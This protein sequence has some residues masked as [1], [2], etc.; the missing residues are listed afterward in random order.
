MH[1]IS[2]FRR[3]LRKVLE[4][5]KYRC[6]VKKYGLLTEA[7]RTLVQKKIDTLDLFS[8]PKISVVM[9]VCNPPLRFLEEAV[10][11]VT[12]QIYPH[13]ELCIVD[14][15]S[16]DEAI[17]MWLRALEQKGLRIKINFLKKR[18][19]IAA[20]TNAALRMASGEF[21][22][23][24]DHDDCFSL[25]AL[26][27][28]ALAIAAIPNVAYLYSDEDKIDA[29]GERCDPFFKP[30]WNPDLLTSL[31]YCS[32][33]SIIRKVIIDEVGGLNSDL[34]GAQDWDLI[35]RVTE[36]VESN[37][38]I[39]LPKVLYHW[40][41]SQNSTARSIRAKP[42][43][44]IASKKVL[45]QALERRG[46]AAI[47]IDLVMAGGHWKVCH[48][49][50]D[51]L[52]FVS[53]IILTHSSIDL[54]K[55]CIESLCSQT[56]YKHY[57]ILI[58]DSNSHD[59]KTLRYYSQIKKEKNIRIIPSPDASNYS[60]MN[61]HAVAHARGEILLLLNNTMEV[62]QPGW[63]AE[64]VAQAV[65]PEVGA[66]GALLYS[67]NGRVQYAGTIL[68]M[69]DLAGDVGK[70]FR[71]QHYVGGN[72]M[73][74]VQNFSALTGACL[75]VRKK[76]YEEVG[77]FDQID[78]P[79]AFSDIDFCLKLQQAGYR[80]VWTPFAELIHHSLAS[81]APE[82]KKRFKK[83]AALLRLRWGE[84]IKDDPAYNPNLTLER[85]DWS[86]AWPP[87]K[88]EN[89]GQRNTCF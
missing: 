20:A 43:V 39:H 17:I 14:D 11:S 87:R 25:D 44:T 79:V 57:E 89:W 56:K 83:E 73:S 80:N 77:G 28:V 31:N 30:D 46:C 52:P 22:A 45:E 38:I 69:G 1:L 62:I 26:A 71:K 88:R 49:L 42:Y 3:R 10:A 64:L 2:L 63:L 19:G 70:F 86:L 21:I 24:L 68:G 48:A 27:E 55:I 6:W 29:R 9:P 54:L 47:G 66:V 5:R 78:L 58:M 60:A 51:V 41:I 84:L 33:L 65:R 82:K 81:A 15:G 74:V 32:H 59:E 37:Q 75:A 36:R 8:L 16:T 67:S 12:S 4:S 50:P 18:S 7:E 76:V 34:E 85:E 35:L 23:F 61:N 13:W 53:I 72:R 40:R